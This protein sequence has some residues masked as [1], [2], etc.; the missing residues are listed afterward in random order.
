M[1]NWVLIWRKIFFGKAECLLC[2][3]SLTQSRKTFLRRHY[4]LRHYEYKE[5]SDYVLSCMGEWVKTH[6]I[7]LKMSHC[8][9]D[10]LF[11]ERKYK[12]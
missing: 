12:K 11:V 7:L 9:P 1:G 6:E 10:Q 3:L 2:Q 8:P 5:L 4:L